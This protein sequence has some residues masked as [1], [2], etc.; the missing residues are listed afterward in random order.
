MF[1]A[2][3]FKGRIHYA[4]KYALEMRWELGN[5]IPKSFGD[6]GDLAQST[7]SP[8]LFHLKY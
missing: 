5:V 3:V 1:V 6:H 2:C 4:D 8:S 7:Q